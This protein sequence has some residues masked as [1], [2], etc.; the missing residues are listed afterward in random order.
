MDWRETHNVAE[1]REPVGVV[2]AEPDPVEYTLWE[3]LPHCPGG[4][5]TFM[6]TKKTGLMVQLACC[7][8]LLGRRAGSQNA[9]IGSSS[10]TWACL[11]LVSFTHCPTA[12]R[13]AASR[14]CIKLPVPLPWS[15]WMSGN[16]G[17]IQESRC[18]RSATTQ[19]SISVSSGS[20][21]SN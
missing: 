2:K 12:A 17:W 1:N 15:L 20:H 16:Q 5:V 7:R 11:S 4:P 9:C 10:T 18:S 19:P 8:K 14:A 3:R 6:S 21:S 13:L